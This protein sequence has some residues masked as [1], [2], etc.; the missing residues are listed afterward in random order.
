MGD[1]KIRLILFASLLMALSSGS[2]SDNSFRTVDGRLLRTGM[3]RIEVLSL[4]GQPYSKDVESYGINIDEH[5]GGRTIETWSYVLQ[6]TIG[7]WFLVSLTLEGGVVTAIWTK[8][9]GRL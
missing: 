1:T 2:Y 3:N 4:V 9:E 6:S 7:G 8:Q 5:S